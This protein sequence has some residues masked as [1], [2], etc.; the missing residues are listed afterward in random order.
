MFLQNK[1]PTQ[2]LILFTIEN[3]FQTKIC[4]MQVQYTVRKQYDRNQY[5]RKV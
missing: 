2:N 3:W 4:S 1:S 5:D